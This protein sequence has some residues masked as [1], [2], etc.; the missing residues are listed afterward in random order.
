MSLCFSP[1]DILFYVK[2]DNNIKYPD[3]KHAI[4][5]KDVKLVASNINNLSRAVGSGNKIKLNNKIKG[6]EI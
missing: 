6:M 5:L 2:R 1:T 3:D 4:D